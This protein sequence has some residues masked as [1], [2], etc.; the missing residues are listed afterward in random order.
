LEHIKTLGDFE[1]VVN[2]HGH[3]ATVKLLVIQAE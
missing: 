1:V 2:L 3:K